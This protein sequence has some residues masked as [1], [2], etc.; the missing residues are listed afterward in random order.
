MKDLKQRIDNDEKELERRDILRQAN[1]ISLETPLYTQ[2]QLGEM[3]EKAMDSFRSVLIRQ[4]D[5]ELEK[6]ADTS[7]TKYVK[8]GLRIAKTIVD[9]LK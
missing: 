8:D 6:W 2:N 4:L 9:N 3:L 5:E 1:P 7:P